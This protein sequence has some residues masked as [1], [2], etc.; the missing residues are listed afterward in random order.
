MESNQ[1]LQRLY[2]LAKEN[3]LTRSKK[4][5]AEQIGASYTTLV[6]TMN[7]EKYYSPH[8]F[9]LAAEDLLRKQGYDPYME[10]VTLNSIMIELK[11]QREM[12]EKLLKKA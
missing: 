5:F 9:I 11:E 4:E 3:G 6:R 1:R 8:K 12:L 2:D 7:G 10:T